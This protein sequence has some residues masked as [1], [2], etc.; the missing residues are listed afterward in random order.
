V[1][2]SR[3]SQRS[4]TADRLL[5][6][7]IELLREK[8]YARFRPAEVGARAGMSE[9]LVFRYFETKNDLVVAAL[10]KYADSIVD[11]VKALPQSLAAAPTRRELLEGAAAL[12]TDPALRW[13]YELFAAASLD[14]QLRERVAPIILDYH[15]RLERAAALIAVRSGG[16]PSSDAIILMRLVIFS[17]QGAALADMTTG[18]TG[19]EHS[20]IAYVLSVIEALYGPE[21]GP[22]PDDGMDQRG[23]SDGPRI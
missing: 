7:A 9:G 5:E 18:P 6:A 22:E 21:G 16:I 2:S 13:G 8:G 19:R 14:A 10:K 3:A 20:L 11:A 15:S 12:T 4:A 1:S 23:L 17:L